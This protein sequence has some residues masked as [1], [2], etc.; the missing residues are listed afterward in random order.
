MKKFVS[1]ILLLMGL[2]LAWAQMPPNSFFVR[3]ARSV[4]ELLQ[5]VRQEP[6]VLD[7]FMRHFQLSREELLDYFRSL[8]TARLP[9]D[10]LFTIYNV[11]H[12]TGEIYSKQRTLKK[13]E[14][15]FV[16][17]SGRPVLQASCGN[18]LVGPRSDGT[19][20]P[21]LGGVSTTSQGLKE[22]SIVSAGETAPLVELQTMEPPSTLLPDVEFVAPPSALQQPATQGQQ[23]QEEA[24]FLIPLTFLPSAL[25]GLN[26][27]P[28]PIVPEPS[29][30][31][32]LAGASSL[33]LA[34][35]KKHSP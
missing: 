32:V 5:Q 4:T 35:R 1:V 33:V 11:N 27:S 34:R 8:R 28:P 31:L 6:V 2:S 16:E 3:P 30:I 14:L 9:A 15:L 21:A 7:R 10:T 12:E 18:P 24:P 17:A 23:Q 13:G 29:A 20:T 25:V 22:I 19:A 26:P